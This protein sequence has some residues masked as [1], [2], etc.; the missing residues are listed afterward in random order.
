MT[1]SHPFKL[2]LLL[3]VDIRLLV[4]PPPRLVPSGMKL[5]VMSA[6]FGH[7]LPEAE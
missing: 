6:G 5:S 3:K 4:T 7:A 1:F 2:A